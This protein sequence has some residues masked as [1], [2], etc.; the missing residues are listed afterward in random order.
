[1]VQNDLEERFLMCTQCVQFEMTDLNK[2]S[3]LTLLF[4]RRGLNEFPIKAF[5][6]DKEKDE[7]KNM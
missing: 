5:G 6:N 2:E 4:L 7:R 3:S 1:M